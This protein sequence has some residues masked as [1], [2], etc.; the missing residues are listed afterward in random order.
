[1]AQ[2]QHKSFCRNCSALCA[3]D[4]TVEDGRIVAV[5]GDGSVSPY[6]GYMCAKGRAAADFHNGDEPRLLQSLKRADD[7]GHV[8]IA[9]ARALDEIAARLADLIATHGPRAVAFYHG[10]GA[11]RS[12][13][14][15]LLE[16][17]LAARIGTPNFFSTMTID[18][19]AKWVTMGRM[20]V[21]ASGKPSTRDI[22]LAVIVGNNPLVSHQ[23]YP[24]AAG[25]SGA[26]GKSLAAAKARGARIVVVDPRRTETAR[27]ADLLIQPL[28][29]HDAALF[30]AVAHILL[31]D[32]TYNRAFCARF[33]AQLD[34]LRAAVA[35]FTPAFAAER[36]GIPVEQIET[37]ARWLG[38]AQRPFVGSGT[39][40][41]MSAHS[42][43]N[44]HMIE[45]VN[46]LVGG[47]RRAGDRVRNPGTLR[48]RKFHE[49]VVPPTRS[50]ERG[51]KCRSADIGPLF[52]ELPTALLPREILTPG[53]DRIRAL[54]VFG[55]NPLPALGDPAQ[56]VPAFEDLELLVCL[57]AR[58]NET[59][60]HAHYVIA[61]TQPFER[62]DL[63]IAG[64]GLYPEAF[65]QYARPAL[66][67]PGDTID[68]WFF[69]WGVAARMGIGLTLKYW[70][71][72]SDYAAL[73][74][75]L[76]L[77]TDQPPD[78]ET[79]IRHLC[80]NSRAPFE[81]LRNHPEGVRPQ[82]EAEFV[83]PAADNGARLQLCP[84]DIAAE[85]Q[86]L[87]RETPD[88]R[89]QYQ[90]SCRR[91][92]EAMNSAY[93]DAPRTLRRHPVN[94]AWMNADNMA[95]EGIADGATI[96]IASEHGRILGIARA[97]PGL[98]RGVVSMTHLY[99]S[100]APAT[101]PH[102]QRG[103]HTGQLTS[104]QRDLEPINFM[105]RFSGVPV[106]LRLHKLAGSPPL[107]FW[108]QRRTSPS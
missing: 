7:G 22:D 47:Y 97:D 48:P 73:P 107:S 27:H 80:E 91:I 32:A 21:M 72:G 104:L 50:W 18:Q 58:M 38:E 85:L 2:Q 100:L 67:R 71:Y 81:T 42:N 9:A 23:T 29:G 79:M 25:D 59:A 83:Q 43:L 37:L 70:S 90:L 65:A 19:S 93:R 63:S 54:I 69:F 106:N 76:D 88:T 4:L 99:G 1:M 49:T 78:A 16:R 75:G 95:D 77:G 98:R 39:G 30:A 82:F 62:H 68:D 33:V 84:P 5:S 11:Y 35:P 108:V 74:G 94:W 3:M 96:E 34:E 101:D 53:P 86:A 45:A 60:Q 8:P 10:T 89:Y 105:P 102:A 103:S 51:P 52:G 20:G 87:L 57:D 92:L 66:P 15:G 17:A 28:P 26:P 12:T 56:A 55:G 31:R 61:T 40:P 36:A 14:G 64:D 44:D 46:A 6:G 41:S 24:F 13:L